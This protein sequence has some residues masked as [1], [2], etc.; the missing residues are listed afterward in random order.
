MTS[1][2]EPTPEPMIPPAIREVLHRWFVLYN[3]LYLAS[4]LCLLTG[5]WLL[6]RE[7][8]RSSSGGAE[9]TLIAVVE[10]YQLLLLASAALL[11]CYARQ[12][13]PA[14]LLALF[15]VFF[16][17]DVTFRTEMAATLG[18]LGPLASATALGLF[19]FKLEALLRIFRL[20]LDRV[21]RGALIGGFACVVVMPRV[22]FD[23]LV[24]GQIAGAGAL[25]VLG[26]LAT[27]VRLAGTP[28]TCDDTLDEW[29]RT[30]LRRAGR[31]ALALWGAFGLYHLV[32]W[33]SAN[34][35]HVGALHLAVLLV[36]A[37]FWVRDEGA[38]WVLAGVLALMGLGDRDLGP[39][40]ALATA[41]VCAFQ[42]VRLG[43][44]RLWVGA[45][46][47][48]WLA[49]RMAHPHLGTADLRWLADL[50]AG[51]ALLAF[52]IRLRLGLAALVLVGGA[53]IAAVRWVPQVRLT[54]I[55]SG[56]LLVAAGF[57]LLVVGVF[58]SLRLRPLPPA[59]VAVPLEPPPSQVAKAEAPLGVVS[60]AVD[61]V[62]PATE[63]PS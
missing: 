8:D 60:E 57:A 14:V 51:A 50:C 61:E 26:S 15:T 22:L 56:A 41:A 49:L 20:R 46:G 33:H 16:S 45:V 19:V 63:A 5:V 48:A 47:G 17:G 43:R 31:G 30:V 13:R 12:A 29:G 42:S 58:V 35:I 6:S 52:T 1:T 10:T 7:L 4:A 59:T 24:P 3:P 11:H 38:A 36:L 44:P 2:S 53:V 27:W 54:P 55:Q 34:G 32:A 21:T 25:L 39:V 40:Y 28:L 37:S 9:I 18:T 62:P 23:H